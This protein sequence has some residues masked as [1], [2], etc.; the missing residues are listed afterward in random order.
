MPGRL[1][2]TVTSWL[3]LFGRLVRLLRKLDYHLFAYEFRGNTDPTAPME[4]QINR[5][6]AGQA[7]NLEKLVKNEPAADRLLIHVGYGHLNKSTNGPVKMMAAR[8][9]EDTGID[10]LTIDHTLFWSPVDSDVICDVSGRPNMGI[11]PAIN[12]FPKPSFTRGRPGWRIRL[13]DRLVEIPKTLIH[14]DKPVIYKT[15]LAGEPDTAVPMDMLLVRPGE[16][17]PL[18]LPPGR[19][20]LSAWTANS[21]WS[22]DMPLTVH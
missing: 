20:R 3:T 6:E 4:T 7:A 5:R 9:R 1:R 12:G 16:D 11:Q 13:G 21:G 17:L 10:P 8:F 14:P 22:G 2:R 19:Y 18:L 15:H